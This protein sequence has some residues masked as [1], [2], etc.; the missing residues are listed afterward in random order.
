MLWIFSLSSPGRRRLDVSL[1]RQ[2]A[3]YAVVVIAGST[4]HGT[5]DPISDVLKLRKNYQTNLKGLSFMIHAD[6]AWGGYFATKVIPPDERPDFEFDPSNMSQRYAF[7]YNSTQGQIG[8]YGTCVSSTLLL[9]T[10]TKVAMSCTLE[11]LFAIGMV[12]KGLQLRGIARCST[13]APMTL[14]RSEST[15]S[16]EGL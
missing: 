6:A 4:E 8:S 14:G 3:V 10:L 16:E 12:A 1:E 9:S 7:C 2:Q 5:V 13:S 15:G 11:V